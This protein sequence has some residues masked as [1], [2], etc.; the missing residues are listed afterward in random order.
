VRFTAAQIA[1]ATGGRV[2]GDS[3]ATVDGAT[4]DSREVQ[5]GQLF[6]PLIAERDGHD[7]VDRAVA[8]GAPVHL[9]QHEATADG[10]TA[11]LVDDTA[12]ALEALGRAARGRLD[13]PV[14]GITGSVGKTTVKD[15]ALGVLGATGRAHGSARSFNNEIGVP[16]TLLATPDDATAVVVEMGARGM[17]HIRSLCAIARPTIGVVTRVAMVHSEMF[18]SIDDIALG[19]GELIEALPSTGTAVLNAGDERV[20]AMAARTDATV[21]TYGVG[22]GE[23]RVE[24]VDVADDLR[25][26]IALATPWGG[27]EVEPAARGAHNAENAAAAAAVGLA[28]GMDLDLVAAGLAEAELSPLRMSVV[29]LESGAVVL[30]DSYNANPTS[31]RA[32]LD[33]LSAVPAQRRVAVLGLMA[34][35]GPESAAEHAAIGSEV[36]GRGIELVAVAAPQYAAERHGGTSVDGIGAAVEVLGD[37][38]EGVA[39][40]AKGSR[41]AGLDELVRRLQAT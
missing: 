2:V 13:V 20:A 16:L 21:L 6:V 1:E 14:V 41:V 26:R 19:K 5:A 9:T 30:D 40:L 3:A 12:A 31:M 8:A 27:I 25:L 10:T 15:L 29:V 22:S 34:E 39:V 7:F 17:G 18:G 28:T 32:A 38:G 4:Q 35:L 37:L 33:A 23:V 36:V 24:R 11:V